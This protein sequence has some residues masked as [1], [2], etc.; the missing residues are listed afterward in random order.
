MHFSDFLRKALFP[1]FAAR[2]AGMEV[3]VRLEAN[4]NVIAILPKSSKQNHIIRIPFNEI[5][6][7][8][9]HVDAAGLGV[10]GGRRTSL[11]TGMTGQSPGS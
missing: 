11:A 6:S 10:P 3:S 7:V 2:V 9:V 8:R 4:L 1:G 5:D